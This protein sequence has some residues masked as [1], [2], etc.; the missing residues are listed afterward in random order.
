MI[1]IQH[2]FANGI[3]HENLFILLIKN[4]SEIINPHVF[5]YGSVVLIKTYK[6]HA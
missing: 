6:L 1:A 3:I 4:C 5:Y 2:S